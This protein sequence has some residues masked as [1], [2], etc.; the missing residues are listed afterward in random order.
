M[1]DVIVIGSGAGG[2]TAALALARAGKKVVVFEQHYLPGGWCHSFPLEGYQFSPG[3]HYIGALN[4]RGY[5]RGIYEGLG[6]SEHLVFLELNPDGYDHVRIGRETFDIPKGRDVYRERLKQRFPREAAGIDRYL[7]TMHAIAVQL[8]KPPSIRGVRDVLALPR[9]YGATLR[10]GWRSVERFLDTCTMDPLLRAILTIQGGDHG[11]PPSKCPTAMHA[12]VVA[13]YF[14]G[15]W[16]PKGGARALPRAFIKELRKHGGEL[17][18]RTPVDRVL[19]DRGRAVG[20]RLSD[21]T[22]VRADTVISNAD[23]HVTYRHLLDEEHVPARVRRRLKRTNYSVSAL[24]LFFATDMDLRGAGVDSGNYWYAPT[25]GDIEGMYQQAGLPD[26]GELDAVRGAFLTA[27]TLKDP[28]KRRDGVHT[29]EAFTFVS[30]EAFARWSGTATGARPGDYHDFKARLTDLMVGVVDEIV[31]GIGDRIEFKE[32]GTPLTNTHY[33]AATR[34]N[35][36]GTEKRLGQIGP[37]SYPLR[38][39]IDGLMMCGASTL[40]HGVAGATMSGLECARLVLGCRPR[41]LL[42][43]RGPTLLT[44]PSD[45]P[46]TWPAQHRPRAP[47]QGERGALA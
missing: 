22:E 2:L 36:Y 41:D 17:H 39:P 24:S 29:C 46:E 3:V 45:R 43:A 7:D 20:V 8:M 30:N 33:V 31:P 44:L 47:Q 32:L 10:H 35:L 25:P 26:L 28:S 13:H 14:E 19:V 38:T 11:M 23:P 16:Y 5:M 15:G 18:V 34:G 6:V 40:G 37:M 21:G 9:R 12:A 42:R 1:P 4:E 27:T